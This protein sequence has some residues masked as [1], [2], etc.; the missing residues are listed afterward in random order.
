MLVKVVGAFK[1]ETHRG[2]KWDLTTWARRERNGVNLTLSFTR[3]TG[4]T[5]KMGSLNKR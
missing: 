5:T 3:S 4:D 1:T 2:R